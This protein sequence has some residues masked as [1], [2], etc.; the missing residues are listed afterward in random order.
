MNQLASKTSV[1][2]G[3][4]AARVLSRLSG[5]LPQW[6]SLLLAIA[7]AWQL[8]MFALQLLTEPSQQLHAV[9]TLQT[10]LAEATR[11]TDIS[12]ITDADLFGD[13]KG[14]GTDDRTELP[15]PGL[16]SDVPETTLDLTLK[17]T[18]W[19]S[20]RDRA[21]AIIEYRN[22]EKVYS[23]GDPVVAG[24]TLY[25][26]EPHRVIL[27]RAGGRLEELSLSEPSRISASARPVNRQSS[28]LSRR[29]VSRNTVLRRAADSGALSEIIRP[30]PHFANGRLKGYR[31]YPGRQRRTFAELGFRPGDL[32]TSIN[33]VPLTDPEQSTNLLAGIDQGSQVTVT[34][35]RNGIPEVITIDLDQL[36]SALQKL[37]PGSQRR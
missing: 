7:V 31:I 4:G 32:A 9:T 23:I 8:A 27:Q 6:A 34:V 2:G 22:E 25:L 1:M 10:G 3:S 29:N 14:T 28:R 18:I 30:Q 35:E 15:E 37:P 24:A 19:D 16:V 12:V 20:E 13:L 33:G 17:G 26:V 21:I 36:S 5:K 11:E